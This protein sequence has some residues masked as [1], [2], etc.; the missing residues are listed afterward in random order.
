M[1]ITE[2]GLTIASKM[3]GC[4]EIGLTNAK[5]IM[6]ISD[7]NVIQKFW[8]IYFHPERIYFDVAML[9]VLTVIVISLLLFT[10]FEWMKAKSHIWHSFLAEI[11]NIFS[12]NLKTTFC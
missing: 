10:Y 7:L 11:S 9:S 12:C 6:I 1:V 2:I 4:L 5:Q 3:K 8:I